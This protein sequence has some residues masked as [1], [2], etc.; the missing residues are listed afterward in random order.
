MKK[1]LFF[2]FLFVCFL[3]VFL[4]SEDTKFYKKECLKFGYSE[5]SKDYKECYNNADN[6]FNYGL[7]YNVDKLYS[8]S[9]KFN[10]NIKWTPHALPNFH[11]L[12]ST[13]CSVSMLSA[14]ANVKLKKIPS[15]F[16]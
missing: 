2:L 8:K 5:K 10:Y 1:I 16:A 4:D 15:R 11:Q 14:S 9:F 7:N 13:Q 6:F 12:N 3:Y